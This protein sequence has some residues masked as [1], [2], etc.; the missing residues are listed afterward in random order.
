MVQDSRAIHIAAIGVYGTTRDSFFGA[1]S[2][3]GTTHFVDI[4]RRRGLRGHEYAYAN[5]TALQA[6]LASMGIAYIHELRLAASKETRDAQLASDKATDTGQRSRS[7]LS[8]E[9]V[10]R[11][12]RESLEGFDVAEFVAQ[13]PRGAR[14][15]LF[16][17]ERSPGAC[18]RSLAADRIAKFLGVAWRDITP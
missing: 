4:R 3:Y 14:I 13:F 9:F 8:P 6:A 16:C 2:A 18:H 11:Y 12:R 7:S 5:A 15:V 10:E 1:L 17:V